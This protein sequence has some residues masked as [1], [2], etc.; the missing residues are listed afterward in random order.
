MKPVTDPDILAQLDAQ[1]PAGLKPV[2]DPGILKQL[3]GPKGNPYQQEQLNEM[4]TTDK[5]IVGVGR[6]MTD[7]GHGVKQIALKAGR[8]VGVVDDKTV[9]DFEGR[10]TEEARLFQPLED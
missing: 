9:K 2:T 7:I 6:G 10:A 8:A 3:D 1:P 4:S 5:A